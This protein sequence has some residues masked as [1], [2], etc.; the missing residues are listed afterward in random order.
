MGNASNPMQEVVFDNV[1][2]TNAGTDPWGSDFYFCDG[3]QGVALGGTEP[4]PPCFT[5]AD[6]AG[7]K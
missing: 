3:V 6:G 2:V 5:T 1:V 7:K 4:M